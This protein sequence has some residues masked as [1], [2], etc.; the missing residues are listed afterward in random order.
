MKA[1]INTI[2]NHLEIYDGPDVTVIPL[3]DVKV[4]FGDITEDLSD[5]IFEWEFEVRLESKPTLKSVD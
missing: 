1:I 4:N 5:I 2:A 3:V